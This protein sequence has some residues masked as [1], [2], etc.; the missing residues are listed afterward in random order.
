MEIHLVMYPEKVR[1]S[2]WEELSNEMAGEGGIL[3][4]RTS[5]EELRG[6]YEQKLAVVLMAD[7]EP[8]GYFAIWPV[9]EK[10]YEVGS[11]FIRKDLRSQ[12]HGTAMYKKITHL[13]ALEGK[14]AFVISKNPAAIK[15]GYRAGFIRNLDWEN[16]VPYEFTCGPCNWVEEEKKPICPDRNVHCTLCIFH[17]GSI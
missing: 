5:P 8:A 2:F 9:S 3:Q 13:S 17:G 11:G 7:G 4:T 16:P 10:F 6:A 15:A 12:G 14:I 1:H